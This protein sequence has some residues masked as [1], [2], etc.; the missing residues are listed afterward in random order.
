MRDYEGGKVRKETWDS[1]TEKARCLKIKD[2]GAA[3]EVYEM[4][5]P[6]RTAGNRPE[7]ERILREIIKMNPVLTSKSGAKARIASQSIGKLVSSEAERTSFNKEAHYL[8][9][10]NID[11]LFINAIEPW[12]FELNPHKNNQGLK[13]RKFL[14]APFQYDG[15]IFIVKFTV[16]SYQDETLL[17]KIYSIEAINTC[18]E[19]ND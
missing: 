16:K 1:S 4:A 2:F 15:D 19:K 14:Y 9:V 3:D 17:D 11:K 12:K 13:E 10:A 7:A 8:A 18:M 6:V 5:K